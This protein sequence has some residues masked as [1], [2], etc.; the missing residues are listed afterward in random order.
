MH[1]PTA[2]RSRHSQLQSVL[3]KGHNVWIHI[4]NA[5]SDART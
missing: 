5:Q 2:S 4:S 3:G 1:I